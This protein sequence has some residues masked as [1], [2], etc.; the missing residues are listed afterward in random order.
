LLAGSPR[1]FDAMLAHVLTKH[2]IEWKG[3][4][5]QGVKGGEAK[6]CWSYQAALGTSTTGDG[7]VIGGDDDDDDDDLPKR[8]R[9]R[10]VVAGGKVSSPYPCTDLCSIQQ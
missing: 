5:S 4:F 3:A 7:G 10:I 1:D 8:K 9:S 6:L 2:S